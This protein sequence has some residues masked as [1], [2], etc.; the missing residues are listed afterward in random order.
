MAG[1]LAGRGRP[2][3]LDPAQDQA[4]PELGLGA[5]SCAVPELAGL[6]PPLIRWPGAP[7]LPGPYAQ[8]PRQLPS[9]LGVP[10]PSRASLAPARFP[11]SFGNGIPHYCLR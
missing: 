1:W 3:L 9:A 7:R 8:G 11:L 10:A 2:R 5:A 6:P 4:G